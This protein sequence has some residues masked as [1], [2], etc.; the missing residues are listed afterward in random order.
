MSH[1]ILCTTHCSTLQSSSDL[2]THNPL[3]LMSGPTSSKPLGPSIFLDSSFTLGRDHRL[4]GGGKDA[5]AG[6]GQAAGLG[7]NAEARMSGRAPR[8]PLSD[9]WSRAADRP[10][11]RRQPPTTRPSAPKDLY[12]LLYT[13]NSPIGSVTT[14][15]RVYCRSQFYVSSIL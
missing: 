8:A 15:N 5:D 10:C 9:V 11:S 3:E 6:L 12:S 4:D 14:S 7:L 2:D 1:D 13:I